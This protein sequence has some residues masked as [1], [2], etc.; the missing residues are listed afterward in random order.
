MAMD[1]LSPFRK[2]W[3]QQK[4][5]STSITLSAEFKSI[6][7][8]KKLLGADCKIEKINPPVFASDAE[9]FCLFPCSW[10]EAQTISKAMIL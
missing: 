5:I 6:S 9:V 4:N 10:E 8:L 3:N 1:I 7:E 2:S